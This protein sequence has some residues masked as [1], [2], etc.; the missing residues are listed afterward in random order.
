[1]CFGDSGFMGYEMREKE[2]E[3]RGR[4]PNLQSRNKLSTKC[5]ILCD[6]EVH[7]TFWSRR[8]LQDVGL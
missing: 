1:V 8:D 7:E 5:S 3:T 6:V 2:G 4:L